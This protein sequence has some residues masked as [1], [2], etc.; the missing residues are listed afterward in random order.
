MTTPVRWIVSILMLVLG[1]GLAVAAVF[2]G[3]GASASRHPSDP[4]RPFPWG[5]AFVR[6]LRRLLRTTWRHLLSPAAPLDK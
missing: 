2:G 4:R 5:L 1:A 3:D 6:W